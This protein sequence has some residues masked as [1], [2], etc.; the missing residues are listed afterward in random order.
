MFLLALSPILWLVV[1]LSILKMAAH[2]ACAIALIISLAV[3]CGIYG[4][5][6]VNA[7]T[8]TLEGVALACWPILLVIIA[9]IFTYNLTLHTKAMDTIKKM[10]T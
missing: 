2:K 8:A 5:E 9:A 1:A 7:A 4:M 6:T 3:G 10:L